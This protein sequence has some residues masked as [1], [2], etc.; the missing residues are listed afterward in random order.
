MRSH[1]QVTRDSVHTGDRVLG[2]K[3]GFPLLLVFSW[4]TWI[5]VASSSR[6]LKVTAE[7]CLVT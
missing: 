4:A 6:G 2:L 1:T 7:T 5:S 3:P